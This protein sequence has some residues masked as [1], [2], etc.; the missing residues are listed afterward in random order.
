LPIKTARIGKNGLILWIKR[1]FLG[2]MGKNMANLA[3]D[4]FPSLVA[5]RDIAF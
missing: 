2:K 5:I 4:K 3:K 1:G